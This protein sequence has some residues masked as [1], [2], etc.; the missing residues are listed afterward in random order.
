[1]IPFERVFVLINRG[2]RRPPL[3][4]HGRGGDEAPPAARA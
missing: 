3:I 2:L 4:H 1:V